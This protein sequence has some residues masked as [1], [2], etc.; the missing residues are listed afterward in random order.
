MKHG[1][2]AAVLTWIYVAAF[3]VPTIPV[4]IYLLQRGTLPTFFE[5]FEMY[6]GPWSSRSEPSTFVWL[7]MAFLIVTLLAA[8]AAWLVWRRRRA[9]GVA[10]LVLLPFEAVFWVGFALP[11]PWVLGVARAALIVLGWR[12]LR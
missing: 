12:S 9:G 1:R 8:G 5:L 6:G 7:L 10:S 3:G 4:A 2:I 11:F